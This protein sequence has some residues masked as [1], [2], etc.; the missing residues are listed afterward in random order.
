MF[1]SDDGTDICHIALHD[2]N[3]DDEMPILSCGDLVS[4]PV[5]MLVISMLSYGT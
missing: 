2:G 4:Y 3:Y 5:I 1:V